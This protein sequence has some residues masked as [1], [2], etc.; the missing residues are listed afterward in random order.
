M[1][2]FINSYFNN[3]ILHYNNAYDKIM[4]SYSLLQLY[5]NNKI[6]YKRIYWN[7]KL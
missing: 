6:L 4:E 3:L 2:N 1:C 5:K 7:K